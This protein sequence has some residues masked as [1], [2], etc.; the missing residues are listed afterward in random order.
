LHF[1]WQDRRWGVSSDV[2]G[3]GPE[4]PDDAQID[5]AQTMAALRREL[6]ALAAE[7]DAAL[8]REAATA[9]AV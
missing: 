7:R 1:C 8:A 5:P 4:I 3:G 9:I 2:T 6:D